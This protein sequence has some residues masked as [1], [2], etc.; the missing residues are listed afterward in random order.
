MEAL[1]FSMNS[2]MGWVT[3]FFWP[4]ARVA[5]VLSV[6]PVIGSAQIP[7]RIR[8]VLSVLITITLLSAVGPIPDVDPLS[9]PGVAVTISQFIIGAL[10]G[11]TLLILFNILSVAG[12]SIAAAMGLGFAMMSDPISGQQTPVVSQ[13]YSIL[14]TLL[15]LALDGHLALIR[16]MANSF[17]LVPVSDVLNPE[18]FWT[19]VAWS[20]VLFAG[21]MMVALPALVAMLAVNLVMGVIT[22]AAPQLN[23]FSVGFPLTMT[24]GFVVILISLPSFAPAFAVLLEESFT[25]ISEALGLLGVR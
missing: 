10:I 3:G 15:F 25:L 7:A 5:G 11:F 6:A 16:L 20:G 2:F 9:L 24:I 14:A 13:F 4:L 23:I 19:V 12:E 21:A 8:I 18:G 17:S 22:R 1:A